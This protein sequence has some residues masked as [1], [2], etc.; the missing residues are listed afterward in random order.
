MKWST[1]AVIECSRETKKYRISGQKDGLFLQD[2]GSFEELER[3]MEGYL[4]P[5][6]RIKFQEW[7][8]ECQNGRPKENGIEI[9]YAD[10]NGNFCWYGLQYT[11]SEG[12]FLIIWEE[13][14]RQLGMEKA[15]RNVQAQKKEQERLLR[16]LNGHLL[17]NTMNVIKG[18]MQYDT[19]L[20]GEAINLL[21]KSIRLGMEMLRSEGPVPFSTELE[22]IRLKAKLEQQ[23]YESLQFYA[24]CPVMDFYVPPF[25]LQRLLEGILGVGVLEMEKEQKLLVKT[26]E[27]NKDII[28]ELGLKNTY[29]Q[30]KR[31][32]DREAAERIEEL[33]G[34]RVSEIKRGAGSIFIEV[35]LPKENARKGV[36]LI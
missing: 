16:Q 22:Y 27:K 18:Y 7:F 8:L 33:L 6:S 32:E 28:I 21:A 9:R 13:I 26:Y 15:F 24:E 12:D 3:D 10:K 17:F 31:L 34:G 36:Y 19:E 35:V 30:E 5:A 29:I 25:S 2:V 23:C 14:S 4:E 11:E 20:A 1:K